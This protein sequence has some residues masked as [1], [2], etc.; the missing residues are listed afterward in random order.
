M[1]A[2]LTALCLSAQ[3][4][5]NKDY[6]VAAY[7]WPSC[8]DDSLAHEYLWSEG[9]GE[10][11]VIKKGDPRFEG[12]YQP[13]KPLWGYELDDDPKVV[14]KWINTALSYGVNTFVYDWYWFKEYP[15]LEGA[16]NDGFLKASNCKDMNFYIMWANHN[17]VYNYWNYHRYGNNKDLLF[18]PK[19]D[20]KNFKIIVD[21]IIRQYFCQP[22][23]LKFDGRPVVSIFSIDNFKKSFGSYGEARK[24]IEY[25][26]N[27]ARKAGYPDIY[28]METIGGAPEPTEINQKYEKEKINGV[29]L[30]AVAF[31]N[32][33]GFDPDYQ[34]H[35]DNALSFLGG[36]EGKLDVPVFPTVSIGW[37]DS[38]R[39]PEK[40][41]NDVTRF[42]HSPEVFAAAL[43]KAK[44][45]V[46]SHPNQPPMLNINAWNEWV[47]GSYL[48][49]DQVTGFG[50][51]EAVKKVMGT[52]HCKRSAHLKVRTES[53]GEVSIDCPNKENWKFDAKLSKSGGVE[54][55]TITMD[56]PQDSYPQYFTV[57]FSVPQ[58]GISNLWAPAG[59]DRKKLFAD[60]GGHY[61]SQLAYGMPLYAFFGTDGKN[62]L[63]V[64]SNEA[65]RKVNASL[66][67]KEEGA[68]A[69]GKLEFFVERNANIR[70]YQTVIRI[71]SRN[72]EWYKSIMDGSQWISEVSGLTPM[73][74]PEAAFD[75]LYSSWY[76]FHQNIKDSD[77]EKEC[78][79]AASLGMKT[80]I[81]DDGWQTDN[82]SRGYAFCGDWQI[83][84]KRFANMK[85]HVEKVHAMGM[86][87]MMWYS[88]PFVGFKSEAYNIYKDKAL[89]VAD[90]MSAIVLDPRFPEVREYL[91][92]TYE[93]AMLEWGLDGFKLDFIDNF[94][95][96]ET[97]PAIAQNYAGRDIKSV[98]EAVDV[99]MK[100][101]SARL[102][103]INPDVLIEFRQN[104]MG[105]AIRQYG[106][107]IR[108]YDCPGDRTT[109]RICIA[110]LRLTSGSSAVH[111][112][113]LEWNI[114][115]KP[116]VAA[117][118]IIS[119]IFGVVQYSL[120]LRDIPSEQTA[121][122]KNWIKFSQDHRQTL[123]HSSFR[124]LHPELLY[125][126]IEA[127]SSTE[128]IVG[129]YEDNSVAVVAT[130]KPTYILNGTM[131]CSLVVEFEGKTKTAISY[132]E[133]G[134]EVSKTRIKS[135]ITRVNIPSGGRLEAK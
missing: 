67:L 52:A 74:I 132:D 38:P 23:Y 116:N 44:D 10:W 119:S 7:I 15:Y 128:K 95:I 53:A 86:K 13:K 130:D 34:K 46:D 112:D 78:G 14:E 109:N 122:I 82:S 102:R 77:I 56:A 68:M 41:A 11:E 22:N 57:S 80:L 124:P 89:W 70:H 49:P 117:L 39:F 91:A 127:E 31:Y 45:Y 118:N 69:S 19:V 121:V 123:L 27:E 33:G 106:N 94:R 5:T 47:E 125:P 50:Y 84:R 21:R 58:N 110:D 93:K 32:M 28:L 108:A 133:Y 26:R 2:L 75:P 55:L 17:V 59:S 126:V 29:G 76:Q 87:Y 24:A 73:N 81:V 134:N 40:G 36:W 100:E 129:I 131:A 12:H 97:D 48:L 111:S 101:I 6:L 107:M 63:T 20:W 51:L 25:F 65:F 3:G 85:S 30:N 54:Y 16:L 98:P 64:T 43:Q 115:E 1:A 96:K 114:G 105:P 113:M 104:Y 60:W 62:R 103:K 66:G 135:G 71:D 4:K 99:L 9:I 61:S 90:R 35:C 88:V 18:D 8:H 79:K 72:I 83:S 42:N 120:M 37:D 92:S